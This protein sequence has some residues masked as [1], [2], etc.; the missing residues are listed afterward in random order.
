MTVESFDIR[1]LLLKYLTELFS[2][3]DENP[4]AEQLKGHAVGFIAPVT[5]QEL[6]D[7]VTS[8]LG[9]MG[10]LTECAIFSEIAI[11]CDLSIDEEHQGKGLGK[12]L[13]NDFIATARRKGAQTQRK[14]FNLLQFYKSQGFE[15]MENTNW[16]IKR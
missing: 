7:Y 16:M 15:L 4:V 11:L 3:T 9:R 10:V 13:L 1:I 6:I 5:E 8:N 14:N 2:P 12:E